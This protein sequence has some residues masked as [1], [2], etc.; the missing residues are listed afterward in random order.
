MQNCNMEKSG[1]FG[2]TAQPHIT[3]NSI[4]MNVLLSPLFEHVSMEEITLRAIPM[5]L[6]FMKNKK[7][8]NNISEP[9]LPKLYHDTTMKVGLVNDK[10]RPQ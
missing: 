2:I 7:I 3:P 8:F 4:L 9:F 5:C 1:V 10:R 6:S